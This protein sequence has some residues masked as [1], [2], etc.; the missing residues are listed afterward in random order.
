VDF[1]HILYQR[2]G[3]VVTVTINRPERRNAL[4]LD[5]VKEMMS[6]LERV[7]A[8]PDVRVLVITGAGDAFCSGA[9]LKD[10]PEMDHRLA[11]EVVRLYLDYVAA[12]RSVE[13]P[14]IAR[15]NGDAIGGG[16]CTALACDIR[17]A[18]EKARLG[19][20]FVN[21]GLCGADMGATYLLPRLVGFGRAAELLLTGDL[22]SAREAQ[23]MGLVNRVVPPEELDAVVDALAARL[24]AGPPLGLRA[25][26]KALNGALDM[27]ATAEFDHELLAQTYCLLSEDYQEGLRAFRERRQPQFRGH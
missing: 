6:A 27:D 3:A 19:F 8:E 24:A 10:A 17:V 22:I 16:C 21:L 4:N 26:K 13:I 23:A 18:A 7:G 9:D 12:V 25:T 2:D 14:V 11:H 15:I 1:K 5:T 20:P